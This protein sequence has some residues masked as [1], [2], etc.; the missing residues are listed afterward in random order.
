MMV[1]VQDADTRL[2][3]RSATTRERITARVVAGRLDRALALGAAPESSPLLGV[4]AQTLAREGY[5]ADLAR[6]LQASV[7]EAFGGYRPRI[8]MAPVQRAAVR[9]TAPLLRELVDRLLAPGAIPVRG[10]ALVQLL[11][12][13]GTGPLYN[14]SGAAELRAFA[15]AALDAMR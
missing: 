4:R 11:L 9:S 1:L 3:A 12:T 5:R 13:D 15:C 2:V 10:I 14:P 8:C 6:S 7:D